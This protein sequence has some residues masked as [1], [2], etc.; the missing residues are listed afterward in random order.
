MGL[1]QG[2]QT[3][4]WTWAHTHKHTS[5]HTLGLSLFVDTPLVELLVSTHT[6]IHTGT[7]L[8]TGP[9]G[10]LGTHADMV[11]RGET[12]LISNPPIPLSLSLL[13][14][15]SPVHSPPITPS[16]NTRVRRSADSIAFFFLPRLVQNYKS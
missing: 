11:M 10:Q 5:P 15:S 9:T 1:P 16:K 4:S 3:H 7:I 14:S 6:Y 12:E 2:M 8:Y 13:P